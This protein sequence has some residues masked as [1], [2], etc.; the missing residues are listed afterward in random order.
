MRTT[1]VAWVMIVVGFSGLAVGLPPF[2]TPTIKD[3]N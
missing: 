3:T 1:V 2:K